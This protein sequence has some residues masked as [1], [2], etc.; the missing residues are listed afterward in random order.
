VPRS[1]RFRQGVQGEGTTIKILIVDDH[2]LFAE[3]LQDALRGRGLDVVGTATSGWEGIKRA[4]AL[5]PDVVIMDLHLPDLDGLSAGRRI[6]AESPNVR[7]IAVTAMENPAAVRRAI[8]EGFQGYLIKTASIEQLAGSII[9]M[10]RTQM[11]LPLDAARSLLGTPVDTGE[12][13]ALARLLTSRE[14]Q[15]LLLLVQGASSSELALRLYLSKNTVRTHV[16]NICA[17]LQVHSRLEAVAFA[18]KH[19]IVEDDATMPTARRSRLQATGPPGG[20]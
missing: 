15:V 6:L 14:R 13:A 17:K 11:V 12:A 19:G 10:S 18:V 9:A 1:I 5:G 16:Q 20:L 4:R 2:A 8:R 7:L 3:V